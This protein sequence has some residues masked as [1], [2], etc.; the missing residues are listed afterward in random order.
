MTRIEAAAFIVIVAFMVAMA[1]IVSRDAVL[2]HRAGT[3][4]ARCWDTVIVRS[5]PGAKRYL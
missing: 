2:G 4:R 5:N 1:M 3:H